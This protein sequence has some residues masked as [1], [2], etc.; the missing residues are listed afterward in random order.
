[1]DELYELFNEIIIFEEEIKSNDRSNRTYPD[2]INARK[3]F[4]DYLEWRFNQIQP[5]LV[6]SDN[7]VKEVEQLKCA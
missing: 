3:V 4:H 2:R 1:M 5:K 7:W 6:A